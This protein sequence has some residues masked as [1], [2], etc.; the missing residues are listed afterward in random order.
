MHNAVKFLVFKFGFTCIII[1]AQ[2][3]KFLVAPI[4]IINISIIISNLPEYLSNLRD[5]FHL[6]DGKA[7]K[8]S[9]EKKSKIE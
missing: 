5:M 7:S 3:P 4:I 9:V 1:Q 6:H 2:I 8:Q